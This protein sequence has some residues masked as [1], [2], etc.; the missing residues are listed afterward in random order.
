MSVVPSRAW[1][2]T[3]IVVPQ[4]HSVVR[5]SAIPSRPPAAQPSP[6]ANSSSRAAAVRAGRRG[7]RGG[8][9]KTPAAGGGGGGLRGGAVIRR[10]AGGR[11]GG[12]QLLDGLRPDRRGGEPRRQ[13]RFGQSRDALKGGHQPRPAAPHLQRRG[14]GQVLDRVVEL[15][16]VQRR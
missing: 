13:R 15:R 14:D 3:S 12:A 16:P 1:R 6:Y 8:G 7:C 5:P 2:R 10:G 9:G 4:T 11:V